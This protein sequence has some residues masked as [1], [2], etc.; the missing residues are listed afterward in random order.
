MVKLIQYDDALTR[1]ALMIKGWIAP[2]IIMLYHMI[3]K[4]RYNT[5][6]GI[7]PML[8]ELADPK[9]IDIL[10]RLRL[11]YISEDLGHISA[12]EEKC[13]KDQL[14]DYFVRKLGTELIAFV[15]RD[16]D[17]IVATAYLHIIEMPAN[18]NVING[19]C[20]EVLNVYTI[21]EYRGRGIS[22]RLIE[23]LI[24]YGRKVNLCRIDLSSTKDGYNIY[25]RVGFEDKKGKYIE[26]RYRYR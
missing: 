22:T 23:D 20:G 16:G 3:T 9:D 1:T 7:L 21:P 13:L 18:T 5:L 6:E 2:T 15:A 8:Y 4:T 24:E 11:A 25:K 17:R 26:M 12:H 14:R 10:I 19:M